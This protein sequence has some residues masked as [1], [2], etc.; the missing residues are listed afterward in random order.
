MRL[1]LC[2]SA[3]VSTSWLGP[4]GCVGVASYAKLLG[5]RSET[6]LDNPKLRF[7]AALGFELVMLGATREASRGSLGAIERPS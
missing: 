2:L 7:H 6:L 1:A 4:S 5:H 3:A